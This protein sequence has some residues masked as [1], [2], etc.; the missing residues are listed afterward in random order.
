M[1]V[2]EAIYFIYK[3]SLLRCGSDLIFTVIELEKDE[4]VTTYFLNKIPG[5]DIKDDNLG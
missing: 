4:L 3:S 5:F 1:V 2:V